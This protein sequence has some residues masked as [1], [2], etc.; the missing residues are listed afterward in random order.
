MDSN[1]LEN[2]WIGQKVWFTFD[3]AGEYIIPQIDLVKIPKRNFNTMEQDK[4]ETELIKDK[5][6]NYSEKFKNIES[7]N[8][9][10]DL[11]N[12]SLTNLNALEKN[13]TKKSFF[14][15]IKR[16]FK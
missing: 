14:Y 12:I 7:L 1:Y 8:N 6:F 3:E 13:N 5:P 9:E 16:L 11:I 2:S 4:I 15:K 10:L